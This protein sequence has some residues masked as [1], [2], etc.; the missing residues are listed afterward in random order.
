MAISKRQYTN[1][2]VLM[3]FY[4]L[5]GMQTDKPS[6]KAR[7]YSLKRARCVFDPTGEIVR[8]TIYLPAN[9]PNYA[10]LFQLLQTAITKLSVLYFEMMAD[11]SILLACWRNGKGPL[12][13]SQNFSRVSTCCHQRS[14]LKCGKTLG[15]SHHRQ[16]AWCRQYSTF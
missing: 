1:K 15:G 6:G 9:R 4:V 7:L 11:G 5:L 10:P 14:A 2:A 12:A 3:H 16:G 13:S 8:F